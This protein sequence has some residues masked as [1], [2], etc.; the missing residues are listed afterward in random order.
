MPRNGH[1]TPFDKAISQRVAAILQRGLP[2]K[3]ACTAAGIGESTY[4]QWLKEGNRAQRR[5]EAG[6]ALT[7]RQVALLEFTETCTRAKA[8]GKVLL[9]E[10]LYSIANAAESEHSV[11]AII[12]LL[13]RMYPEQFGLRRARSETL[14]LE[15]LRRE[16]E[17]TVRVVIDAH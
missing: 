5:Q 6:H 9:V 8:E 10:R 13:E 14:E 3:D 1:V 16:K 15:P 4:Y 12:F 17:I 11:D 2:G 7:A